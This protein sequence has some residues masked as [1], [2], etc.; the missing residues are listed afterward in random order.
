MNPIR[1][2]CL[3]HVPYESSGIIQYWAEVG[4][5]EFS[6]TLLYDNEDL[7][8]TKHFDWLIVMGGPMSANDEDKY[9]WMTK[10]KQLIE[11]AI[12]EG[13]TV[14]GICLGA[15]LVADVLGANVHVSKAK[16]I[17]WHQVNLT[18]KAKDLDLFESIPEEFMAF[19]WHSE[20][21]DIP[22]RAIHIASSQA[23][24]NQGFIYKE[25]VIGLQFH[26]EMTSASILDVIENSRGDINNGK[27]VQTE[28]DIIRNIQNTKT[29]NKLI[30]ELLSRVLEKQPKTIGRVS[31]KA[32][33]K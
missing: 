28:S 21:F 27:Y 32:K 11:K 22:A 31:K 6:R 17:G 25:H 19:Q 23:C 4:E 7:P 20:T 3:E 8:I 1:I 16:E 30:E 15:Q 2:R 29:C 13:K 9:R 26:L 14:I 33:I 18:P 10:E 12:T 5:H 24:S